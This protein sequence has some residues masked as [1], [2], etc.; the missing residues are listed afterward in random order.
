MTISP[1]ILSLIDEIR[2]D[3]VHGASE[4]ARQAINV[5]KTAAERSRAGSAGELLLEQRAVGEKLMSARPAM[6]PLF[7]IVSRLLTALK[8][9]EGV[10]VNEVR[11]FTIARAEELIRQSLE[12]VERIARHASELIAGGD[13][14]MTHSYSSTVVAA[15]KAAFRKHPDI[16]AIVTRSGAGR[17]E[18]KTAKQLSASGIPV[19]FIDDTALGLYV[20]MATKVL[21]GADRIC[22]D[23]SLVNGIG[24]YPLALASAKAGVPF[25][26]LCETLKFDPRLKGDEVELEEKQPSEV[27][28][29]GRLPPE[30]KVANP[31]FDVT[32]PELITGVVTEDG[33]LTPEDVIRKLA[34]LPWLELP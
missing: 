18:E 13:R 24:T 4:L 12:A 8:A 6:A 14:I 5:L 29:P 32:P 16:E 1:E 9:T 28:E 2:D 27:L 15:L 26:V 3:R 23:G 21:V 11:R 17:I 31:Y 30:V 25:Y 33:L 10:D 34:N 22:S 7:N 19:A 20:K